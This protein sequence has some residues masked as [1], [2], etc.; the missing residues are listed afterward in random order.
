MAVALL[1]SV[2]SLTEDQFARALDLDQELRIS[3]ELQRIRTVAL[4]VGALDD[5]LGTERATLIQSHELRAELA[6]YQAVIGELDEIGGLL[7][8]VSIDAFVSFNLFPESHRELV[9]LL[10]AKLGFWFGYRVTL[11]QLLAQGQVVSTMIEEQLQ[12]AG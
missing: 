3:I 2:S 1:D 9:A 6:Q 11:D 12:G 10:R 4:R 7:G 8:A 5:I